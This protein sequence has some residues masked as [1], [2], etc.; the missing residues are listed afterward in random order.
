MSDSESDNDSNITITFHSYE[1]VTPPNVIIHNFDY[2]QFEFR[3]IRQLSTSHF[4]PL[5]IFNLLSPQHIERHAIDIAI[6]ESFEDYETT[7]RKLDQLI[8]VDCFKYNPQKHDVGEDKDCS[9]CQNEYK[10]GED[11]SILNCEHIFHTKCVEEWGLY[12]AEC[13]LCRHKIP[14]IEKDRII[15]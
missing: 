11:L 12:K 5:N 14:V 8:D 4:L 7:E 13:P 9:I 3:P 2:D 6:Q 15:P 1:T 10:N